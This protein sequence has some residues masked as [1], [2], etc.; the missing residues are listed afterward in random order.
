MAVKWRTWAFG[1]VLIA[2]GVRGVLAAESDQPPSDIWFE[3]ATIISEGA[4]LHAERFGPRGNGDARYPTLIL[5]HGWGGNAAMLRADAIYFA[6]AGFYVVTFDYRGWGA[7]EG[8]VILVDPAPRDRKQT[9]FTA[10]VREV[11]E[12]VDPLDQA[13]DL[14]NVLHWVQGEPRCDRERIGLWG[15][16]YSGGHVVYAA[17]MDARVKALVAQVPALDSRFVVEDPRQ[18]ELTYQEATRRARGELGYPPPGARV[19]GNLRGAP[20]REKL[21]HYA[22]VELADQAPGCAMLFL[23]AEREELFD[24]RQHAIA[25]YER[26]R[27]PKKLI[28]LP[29]I[30]HYGVYLQARAKCQKLA[31]EWFNEHLKSKDATDNKA[32]RNSLGPSD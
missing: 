27:G 29:G 10:L 7:S 13:T 5:S 12:V 20:I 32:T 14:I 11:R 26:A 31:L 18:R 4:R 3:P 6:R 9:T 16:S 24:N 1:V 30:T 17:A 2:V 15:T 25:A 23:I 19:I 22:P 8:R 28:T 21:M